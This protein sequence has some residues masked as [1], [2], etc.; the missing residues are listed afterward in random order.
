VIAI[1]EDVEHDS[2]VIEVAVPDGMTTLE[3]IGLMEIAKTQHLQS[4]HNQGPSVY[5]APDGD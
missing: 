4:K 1:V 2:I 3:S 5:Q